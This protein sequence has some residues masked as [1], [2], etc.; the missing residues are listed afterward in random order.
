MLINFRLQA[1][2][3]NNVKTI[4]QWKLQGFFLRIFTVVNQQQ[5]RCKHIK[6]K[7]ITFVS[8]LPLH[9]FAS[10]DL[11]FLHTIFTKITFG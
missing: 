10:I 1:T 3:A 9:V 8:T 4:I 11:N 6:E 2:S 7:S 5:S